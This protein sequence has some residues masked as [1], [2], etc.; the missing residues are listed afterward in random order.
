MS[1]GVCSYKRSYHIHAQ[2][3][4]F[5]PIMLYSFIVL[6]LPI[7]R[8]Q[9]TVTTTGMELIQQDG[10]KTKLVFNERNQRKTLKIIH[11]WHDNVNSSLEI[12]ILQSNS[13]FASQ[14]NERI[15]IKAKGSGS[16]RGEGIL[17]L[18]FIGVLKMLNK[19][20]V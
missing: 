12:N 19:Y 7:V 16:C 17:I 18:R 9:A 6:L 3:F 13:T 14:A 2:R 11:Y 8:H 20:F 1:T 15:R 5:R 10:N 4:P